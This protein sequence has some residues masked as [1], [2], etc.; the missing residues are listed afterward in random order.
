MNK[1]YCVSDF[2]ANNTIENGAMYG[3]IHHCNT[4]AR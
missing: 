1:Y 3:I 2:K 4:L